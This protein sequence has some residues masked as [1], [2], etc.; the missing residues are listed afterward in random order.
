MVLGWYKTTAKIAYE[1]DRKDLAGWEALKNSSD[2]NDKAAVKEYDKEGKKR[3]IMALHF[4]G[5]NNVTYSD[6][7][8]DVHNQWLVQGRDT[9][10]TWINHTICLCE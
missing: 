5:L 1:A 9:M 3:F 6:I 7:E 4:E 10:P 2:A 8:K